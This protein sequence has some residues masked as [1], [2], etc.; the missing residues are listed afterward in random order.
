MLA[1]LHDMQ[2]PEE[3]ARLPTWKAHHLSGSRAG[4]W[5]LRVTRNWPPT[6]GSIRRKSLC[7]RSILRTITKQE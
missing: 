7:A 6:F 4:T 5:S 1:F 3:L 2:A